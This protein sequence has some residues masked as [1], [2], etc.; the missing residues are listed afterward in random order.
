MMLTIAD[1]ENHNSIENDA[2]DDVDKE[3]RADDSWSGYSAA[4]VNGDSEASVNKARVA[5][6]QLLLRLTA[7]RF[8]SLVNTFLIRILAH[9]AATH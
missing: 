5:V 8:Q 9:F 6:C 3:V 7:S 4:K 2:E 1:S